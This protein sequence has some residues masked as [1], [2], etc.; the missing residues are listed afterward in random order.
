MPS[1]LLFVLHHYAGDRPEYAP[2]YHSARPERRALRVASLA[3]CL[4]G[5]WETFGGLRSRMAFEAGRLEFDPLP[6]RWEV[7]VVVCVWRDQHV[8]A[9]LRVP[10]GRFTVARHDGLDDPIRL[11]FAGHRE[12]AAR[13]AGF[14]F[15]CHL[16]DDT[17][18]SDPLFFDKLR[19][20]NAHAGGPGSVLVPHRF[21]AAGGRACLVDGRV[22]DVNLGA[23]VRDI[24]LPVLGGQ[25]VCRR[26]ANPYSGC[27]FLDGPQ[28]ARLL[29]CGH[30]PGADASW[31]GPLESS[32]SLP[33][34][35]TFA[36]YKPPV[37]S[38]FLEVR[39]HGD[40]YVG[41]SP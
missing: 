26:P 24:P 16:E 6:V 4:N 28:L 15:Y 21:E 41:A 33:L 12:V 35:R 3:A 5:I 14:D 9:D 32:M 2:A 17:V 1:R 40:R 20:F 11:G 30:Y 34:M 10:T 31:I 18:L 23:P 8:L 37:E 36:V 7:E 22:G 29:A 25:V 13:A 39:H 38:G 19:H 27:Y